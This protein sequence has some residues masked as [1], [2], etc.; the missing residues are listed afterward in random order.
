M[1][2]MCV[3][4]KKNKLSLYPEI[5][6]GT[7]AVIVALSSA[8]YAALDN[9]DNE[10]KPLSGQMR[11]FDPFALRTITPVTGSSSNPAISNSGI[12]LSPV[13]IPFRPALRSPYRPPWVPGPPPWPPG[14]P[15]WPPGPPQ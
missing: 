2:E 1:K 14:P 10:N 3:R 8:A 12:R 11:L 9:T 15:P 5:I 6:L 13:R 4:N 7:L